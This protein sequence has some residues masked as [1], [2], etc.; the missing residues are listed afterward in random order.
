MPSDCQAD[1]LFETLRRVRE[2]LSDGRR[3]LTAAADAERW[4]VLALARWE[5]LNALSRLSHYKQ[6]CLF[7][8]IR[9]KG[10]QEMN[11]RAQQL[12]EKNAA[13]LDE[14]GRFVERWALTSPLSIDAAYQAE[15][16]RISRLIEQHITDDGHQ[17]RALLADMEV[18]SN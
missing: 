9:I 3:L 17:I 6:H 14:Y 7:D 11:E 10:S 1:Q 12:M 5:M 16:L 18:S 8:P 13:L 15:A 4:K 2:I